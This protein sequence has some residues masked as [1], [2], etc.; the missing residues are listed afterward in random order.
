M[1]A[2]GPRGAARA[3]QAAQALL[4][5]SRDYVLGLQ[6]GRQEPPQVLLS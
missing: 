2:S 6:R 1:Q 5:V 4:S 3:L